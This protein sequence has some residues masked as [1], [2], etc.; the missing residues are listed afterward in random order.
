MLLYEVGINSYPLFRS[1]SENDIDFQ[2]FILS[3]RIPRQK[4]IKC[5][6]QYSKQIIM[7]F[8]MESLVFDENHFGVSSEKCLIQY[9]SRR[10]K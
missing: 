5:F 2:R 3:S 9:L 10:K 8:A 6:H 7:L 4:Q 1:A